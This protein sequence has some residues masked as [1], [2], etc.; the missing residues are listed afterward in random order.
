MTHENISQTKSQLR[1]HF[2][3]LR[4][5]LLQDEVKINSQKINENFINNLLPKLLEKKPDAKFSIYIA[6]ANEVSTE[7]ICEHFINNKIIFSY[8]IITQKNSPL[9]FVK[10]QQNQVFAANKFFPKI[11]EPQNGEIIIPDIL[12]M[13]LL[14]FDKKLNRLGMG[15]GFFDRTLSNFATLNHKITKIGLGY[16]FQ[17]YDGT[18]PTEKTDQTLDFIASEH[19]IFS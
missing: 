15:G 13:P 11:I 3:A 17:L 7:A 16:G 5:A 14:A 18:L 9:Q 1:N 19:D 4:L 6:S 12:I 8:P 10:H 2:K